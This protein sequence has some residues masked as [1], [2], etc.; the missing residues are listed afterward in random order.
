MLVIA[1]VKREGLGDVRKGGARGS[2]LSE[3][4]GHVSIAAAYRGGALL[5]E[6]FTYH[7]KHGLRRTLSSRNPT[8]MPMRYNSPRTNIPR[9][10]LIILIGG[11]S[12]EQ[13]N[14]SEDVEA[15]RATPIPW[16]ESL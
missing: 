6:P 3:G 16:D 15:K 4:L 2:F 12:L 1:R 11:C 13:L 14:R 10:K 9:S 8:N 7:P 5:S